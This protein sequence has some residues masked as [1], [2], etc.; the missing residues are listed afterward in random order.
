ML[1]FFN[2]RWYRWSDG[3]FYWGK[4]TH[5]SGALWL[6]LWGETSSGKW[7]NT[8]IILL[9]VSTW[10]RDVAT[11]KDCVVMSS[12]FVGMRVLATIG[13]LQNGHMVYFYMQILLILDWMRL[14]STKCRPTKKRQCCPLIPGSEKGFETLL[15]PSCLGNKTFT[16]NGSKNNET[17]FKLHCGDL[18]SFLQ[19]LIRYMLSLFSYN[20][21]RARNGCWSQW[22]S[23]FDS[24]DKVQAVPLLW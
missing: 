14:N 12:V 17:H 9:H 4:H 15:R 21:C 13:E 10:Y 16:S 24:G 1:P 23:L 19:S 20:P 3:T 22:P 2:S 5:H 6:P 8:R 18:T 7:L 11:I